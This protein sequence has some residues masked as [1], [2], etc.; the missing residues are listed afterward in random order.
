MKEKVEKITE[1]QGEFRETE[2]RYP[3]AQVMLQHRRDVRQKRRK[4]GIDRGENT[5]GLY[6]KQRGNMTGVLQ[7]YQATPTQNISLQLGRQ[8]FPLV[9]FPFLYSS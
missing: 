9:R 1:D 4:E 3:A 7:V 6:L 2:K 8:Q 5:A